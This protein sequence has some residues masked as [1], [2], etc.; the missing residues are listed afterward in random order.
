MNLSRREYI[1]AIATLFVGLYGGLFYYA[2]TRRTWFETLRAERE[3][4]QASLRDSR[5]LVA[6]RGAWE[7]R[8]AERQ[9]LM[10][11]FPRDQQMDVH[12]LSVVEG[13]A[14]KHNLA[15]LRHEP[16][17][18]R[19]EGPIHELPIYVRQW[20]GSLGALIHFLFDLQQEGAMIDVRYLH[21]RPKSRTIRHGR[22]DLYC[23][24]RR[25]T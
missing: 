21:V 6:E 18:P 2:S 24:Y 19:K 22:L 1:L 20:E 7:E 17:E 10:P 23:A 12:W 8:M 25:E 5:S 13:V 14:A 11:V 15:L 9:N 3:Q 16:G 4:L